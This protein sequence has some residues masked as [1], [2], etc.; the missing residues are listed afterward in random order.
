MDPQLYLAFVL[1]SIFMILIPGPS[2]MLTV[3]HALA[4]GWRR[5]LATVAG[6][7]VG[8]G[9]QLAVALVGLTSLM[10]FLAEWFEVVR[11]L[12]VAYLVWLGIRAWRAP[13]E[14]GETGAPQGNG[15]SLFLQGLIVT[16]PNPKSLIFFAAFFPQFVDCLLYTS[17]S[18]RD[19]ST[20][21]MP[22]SA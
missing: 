4:H 19:L 13:I 3:G 12:G 17:P 20:S 10:L 1:A 14:D 5:S 11:W 9:L 16:I 7:T 18:P 21:R 22:S 2:V 6:A 15:R 8:V